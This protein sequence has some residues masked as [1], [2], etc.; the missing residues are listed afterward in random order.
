MAIDDNRARHTEAPC[1]ILGLNPEKHRGLPWSNRS[2]S[3]LRS[4]A[5][6]RWPTPLAP[7]AVW[8]LVPRTRICDQTNSAVFHAQPIAHDAGALPRVIRHVAQPEPHKVVVAL[9]LDAPD[10]DRG[11]GEIPGQVVRSIR[12]RSGRRRLRPPGCRRTRA[13]RHQREQS[14]NGISQT[15]HRVRLAGR[16]GYGPYAV[17]GARPF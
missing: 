10:G 5:A 15:V 9:L 4:V 14:E 13:S 17:S 8:I 1:I 2:R 7:G 3:W 11:F 12:R 16:W 6:S